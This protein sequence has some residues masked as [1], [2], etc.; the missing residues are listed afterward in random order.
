M[1]RVISSAQTFMMK[2]IF[3]VLWICVFGAV[4]VTM[5]MKGAP[6]FPLAGMFP[7]VWIL[8]SLSWYWFAGRLKKVTLET[9]GLL[10]SNYFREVRVSF[11]HITDVSG[12][13]WINTRQITVT[14]DRDIGFGTSIIFMPKAQF[15]WPGQEHPMAQELRDLVR[16]SDDI[17]IGARQ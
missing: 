3:P 2:F 10:I 16:Q 7:V 13:R 5:L 15:L 1:P 11:R 12:S 14:F 4:T 8:G 9:D 17:D 6:G